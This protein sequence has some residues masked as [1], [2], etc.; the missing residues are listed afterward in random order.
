[1]AETAK[2]IALAADCDDDLIGRT[3]N[4][5]FGQ[6]ITVWE[7]A[8]SIAR[9]CG[10]RDLKPIYAEPRPGD[11]PRLH[12]DIR[13]ATASAR[14]SKLAS[15]FGKASAT[16]SLAS[17]F[18]VTTSRHYSTTT[19]RIGRCLLPERPQGALSRRTMGPTLTNE[20]GRGRAEL[21]A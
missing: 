18:C 4:I 16:T 1:M 14:F 11:V 10:R 12:A 5:A 3:S 15:I 17:G 19:C 20:R 13:L 2:D 21:R 6:M 9:C 7:I 8:E